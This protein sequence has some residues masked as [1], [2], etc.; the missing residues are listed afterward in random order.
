MQPSLR[1]TVRESYRVVMEFYE[2]SLIL[3]YVLSC[4]RVLNP[5]KEES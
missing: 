4:Y 2:T 1:M 5:I 3:N